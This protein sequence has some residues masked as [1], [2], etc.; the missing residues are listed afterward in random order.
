MVER[1]KPHPDLFLLAARSMGCQPGETIVVEDG[2]LGA[3]AGRLAGMAVLGYASIGNA[4][5]LEAEGAVVFRS[6]SEL[7]S[8]LALA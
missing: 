8:L 3:R 2:V 7:P 4:E 5:R 6:M 1:G